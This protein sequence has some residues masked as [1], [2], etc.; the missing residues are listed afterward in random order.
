MRAELVGWLRRAQ[1]AGL[2][3]EDVVALVDTT[4]R[5]TPP[6]SVDRSWEPRRHCSRNQSES[7]GGHGM[8]M[9]LETVEL[10][11]K[12][13]HAWAVRDCS[14]RLPQGR[15]AALVGP[16]GAGK[17][18]LLHLAVGL[19]APDAGAVRVFGA[20]AVRQHLDPGRHRV[21]R[22]GHPVVRG[23]HGRRA[24]RPWAAS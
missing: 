4:I 20:R 1:A 22:P 7:P 9:A 17:S 10:G 11:K 19:L 23:L 8:D 3:E 16:N 2:T 13:G 21:R 24:G 6:A 5:A 12:Y 18:T 15:I 14:L